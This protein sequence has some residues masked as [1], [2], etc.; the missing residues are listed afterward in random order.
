MD[1]K[2]INEKHGVGV[3]TLDGWY[4]DDACTQ[5]VDWNT[6]MYEGLTVYAK[7][8]QIQYRVFLHPNAGTTDNPDS[9]LDLG[10][11]GQSTSFRVSYGGKVSLPTTMKRAG[12]E[13]V[14]WYTDP[15]CTKVFDAD[16]FTLND[17][18]VTTPY[19]TSQSTECD[20][21]GNAIKDTTNKDVENNRYWITKQFDVYAKWRATL[22][23]ARV[24]R[25]L[26]DAAD[27]PKRIRFRPI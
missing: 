18:T 8:R 21:W 9:T 15:A 20:K 24:A 16:V 14:G 6:Q 13:L 3:K 19:D 23:G 5:A 11:D 1:I 10:S 7:W 4:Y 25:L 2:A 12:Y 22:D 27:Q 17:T 26:G